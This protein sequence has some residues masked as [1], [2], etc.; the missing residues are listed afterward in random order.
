M[1][2]QVEE[3]S[4]LGQ[5]V[6]ERVYQDKKWGTQF[7]DKNTVNDWGAYIGIYLAKATDMSAGNG[8][9]YKALIKV[10]ALAVA[11]LETM[12]RNGRF[13]PRHYDVVVPATTKVA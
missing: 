5:I 10:A 4:I 12:E 13:P 1:T 11:A 9:Q 7:D 8:E 6:A 3:K 2:I